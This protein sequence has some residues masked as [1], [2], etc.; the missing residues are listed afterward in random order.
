MAGV[1]KL[2]TGLVALL[3]V[4][5]YSSHLRRTTRSALAGL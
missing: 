3:H 1:A 4:Y 5:F 2:L